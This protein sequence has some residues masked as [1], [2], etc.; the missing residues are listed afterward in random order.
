MRVKPLKW[1]GGK[2]YLAKRI[3]DLMPSHVHYV[4]T[5]FGGG[6]VLLE[7][8][9]ELIEGHSEVANDINSELM[10]FW[11]VLQHESLF[12]NFRRLIEAV[13]LSEESFDTAVKKME[14]VRKSF[15]PER[16]PFGGVDS[17]RRAAWFFIRY[18]QSRQG[19]GRDFATLSKTRTRRGMNEQASSWMA[20]VECL[21]EAH[22]RMMRVA[23]KCR[24]AVDVIKSEDSEYTLFYI[25]PTYMHETR[26]TIGDYHY[27]MSDLDHAMLLLTLADPESPIFVSDIG[28]VPFDQDKQDMIKA[29]EY[30]RLKG[31]FILSGYRSETYDIIAEHAGWHRIDIEIDNKASSKKEKPKKTECLW[32]N[33]EPV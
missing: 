18:R 28:V 8:P 23:L 13:P 21:P 29:L 6:R 33:F 27:E 24:D 14:H 4:E 31:K 26:V 32:M 9:P 22:E 7:K 1:H 12:A 19:L 16:P 30:F 17:V 25:D 11:H 2:H 3:I 20:S 15:A 5:H 10:T